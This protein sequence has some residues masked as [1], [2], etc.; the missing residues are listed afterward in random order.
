MAFRDNHLTMMKNVSRS[1][2]INLRSGAHSTTDVRE[3]EY[4]STMKM[5]PVFTLLSSLALCCFFLE[6]ASKGPE[7]DECSLYPEPAKGQDTVCTREYKP[8]CGSDGKTYGNLCLFCVAKRQ[9]G[10]KLTIKHQ[11]PCEKKDECSLYPEPAKGQDT[12][13]TREYKPVCGSDGKTYNNLCLFC[14]AKRQSGGQLTIKHHGPCEKKDECS[15]YPEPAKG[16]NAV[17]CTMEH[18]P[19]CGSDGKTYGNLCLFCAAKR[20]SGGHLTIKHKGPC[21]KKDECSKYPEP[22]KGQETACTLEY[23]PVCGSDGKTYGNLC[24]F[25]AAQRTNDGKFHGNPRN[26]INQQKKAISFFYAQIPCFF[27]FSTKN[28]LS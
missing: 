7:E 8:V 17:L 23:K 24:Q 16:Q 13:C 2:N 4:N 19:V 18:N 12:A 21:E 28:R 14:A 6:V 22:A 20:Q 10:G 25:C 1:I 5:S 11:G 3:T 9:S 27:D 26:L 15:L